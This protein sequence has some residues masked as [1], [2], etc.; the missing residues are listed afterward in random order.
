MWFLAYDSQ[1]QSKKE[2]GFT[3]VEMLLVM[4][5]MG[6]LTAI[7]LPGLN[8]VQNKA[9]EMSVKSVGQSIQL[10]LETH[11]LD[12]GAYPTETDISAL[13]TLLVENNDLASLPKNPFTGTLFSSS[14]SSGRIEYNPSNDAYSLSARG[15]NNEKVLVEFSS[16]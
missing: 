6:I 16:L 11:Y 9:K 13:L 14:D 7:A 10:A 15:K 8:K 2:A 5:V 1:D 4:A 3:L 12:Q